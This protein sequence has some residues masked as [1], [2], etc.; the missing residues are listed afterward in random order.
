[1]KENRYSH[2]SNTRND[3]E[4][5][6]RVVPITINLVCITAVRLKNKAQSSPGVQLSPVDGKFF[7]QPRLQ[8]CGWQMH[9]AHRPTMR[10]WL[11]KS[12]EIMLTMRKRRPS[13]GLR[14]DELLAANINTLS[15]EYEPSNKALASSSQLL[16]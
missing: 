14:Y 4:F 11:T 16:H 1:L 6:Q 7:L 13:G 5:N 3:A 2:I 10:K 8:R 15:F 9:M 12:E